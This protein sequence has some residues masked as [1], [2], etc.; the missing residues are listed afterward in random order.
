[1]RSAICSDVVILFFFSVTIV[2]LVV[3][4]DRKSVRAVKVK[5]T[6]FIWGFRLVSE[7]LNYMSVGDLGAGTML[8]IG[9]NDFR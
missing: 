1:M 8:L 3:K 7:I 4:A 2:L 5:I 9:G 6:F